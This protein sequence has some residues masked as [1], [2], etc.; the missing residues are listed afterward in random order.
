LES[1]HARTINQGVA[2]QKARSDQF[3]SVKLAPRQNAISIR[4]HAQ[5]QAYLD[6]TNNP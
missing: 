5:Q 4:H 2:R 1:V 3:A 6:S